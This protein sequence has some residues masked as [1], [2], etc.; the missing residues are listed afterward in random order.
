MADFLYHITTETEAARAAAAGN[1]RHPS[2]ESEGFIHLST[3]EQLLIPAN[4]RYSGHHDLVVLVVDPS[5]LIAD[6][7][8]E[9]SYGSGIEF[10][11]LYRQ[12]DWSSVVRV[13]EFPCGEDGRFSLPPS[14]SEPGI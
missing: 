6:L 14:L 12:F 4:E 1:Y 2:L 3:L 5:G 7:V 10:P 11:H 8:F 13:V 9:D